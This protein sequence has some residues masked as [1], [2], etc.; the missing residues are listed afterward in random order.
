VNFTPSYTGGSGT[1]LVLL[2]GIMGTWNVW[3]P[4]LPLLEKHHAVYAPTLPG[5]AGASPL[6]PDVPPSIA[7]MVDAVEADLDRA[8]I[9]T[10]HFVGNS[11]GGWLALELARRGRA[12]L[13][14][15]FGPAGGWQSH[16]RLKGLLA[17][18]RISFWL[19]RKLARWADAIA[20]R[21]R[22]RKLL[23]FTQVQHP[24]RVPAEALAAALRSSLHAPVVSG[25]LKAVD[26]SPFA[27]LTEETD[28]PIRIVWAEKDRIIPWKHFGAALVERLPGADVVRLT[29]IGHVPM[30]DAPDEVARLVL[31][32]TGAADSSTGSGTASQE[33]A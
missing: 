31:E 3:E 4:V 8:G 12:R 10:A 20:R 17:G 5:H 32:V 26:K 33:T 22:L 1:P 24:D 19:T 14:V 23:L 7:A 11:L 30:Y 16:R 2:H 21:P 18:F 6:G 25:L 28:I 13:V 15:A 27:A 29:G 9:G